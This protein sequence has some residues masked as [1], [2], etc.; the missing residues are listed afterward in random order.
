EDRAAETAAVKQTFRDFVATF[1]AGDPK[2]IASFLKEPVII[3]GSGTVLGTTSEIE[4]WAADT[5]SQLQSRGY[6]DF[7]FDQLEAR[8]L[9][10]NVAFLSY[11]GQRKTKDGAVI[12]KVAGSMF[13]RKTDAGWKMVTV[14]HGYPPADFIKLD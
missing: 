3:V 13:F 9:G 2:K 6:A 5:R 7:A 10:Q 11:S 8:P 12:E 4:K 1:V 14:P